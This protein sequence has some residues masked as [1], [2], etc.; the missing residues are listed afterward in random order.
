MNILNIKSPDTKSPKSPSLY[1]W[2]KS[3]FLN[4]SIYMT[5]MYTTPTFKT[6]VFHLATYVEPF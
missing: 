2:P 4:A 3:P 5:H 1:L 6:E